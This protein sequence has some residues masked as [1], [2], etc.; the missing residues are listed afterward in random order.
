VVLKLAMPASAWQPELVRGRE[1]PPLGWVSRRFDVKQPTTV[2]VWRG[3]CQGRTEL[4]TE[5][6]WGFQNGGDGS[7]GNG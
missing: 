4:V 2:A 5:L 1:A 7:G 6:T 3:A